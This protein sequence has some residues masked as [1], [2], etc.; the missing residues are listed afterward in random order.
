MNKRIVLNSRPIGMPVGQ[1]GKLLGCRAIG[2]AGTDEKIST[3]KNE[4]RFR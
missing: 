2:I 3:L 4:I 1:I